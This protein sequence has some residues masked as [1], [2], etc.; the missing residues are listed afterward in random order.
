MQLLAVK[1]GFHILQAGGACYLG[2]HQSKQMIPGPETFEML[3]CV[4]APD[5]FVENGAR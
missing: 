2:V 4:Q 5:V 1:A 3:V